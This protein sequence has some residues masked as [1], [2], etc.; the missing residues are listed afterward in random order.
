MLT[1]NQADLVDPNHAR[2][3][4]ELLND[5]AEDPMGGGR[6]LS[7]YA[8]QNLIS[9]L[10]Q[11]SDLLAILAFEGR[12]PAGLIIAF[13]GFS[14]F[15]CAPL[16][17]IHDVIVAKNFRRDGVSRTMFEFI[18]KIALDRNYCKLTLEVLEGNRAAQSAYRSFGFG[19]YELDPETGT[20]LFW[21]KILQ[22]L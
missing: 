12:E 20:A 2:A 6:P 5:Y 18:E 17:N 10:Q 14:T 3:L 16:L 19:D 15:L 9:K 22:Q 4:I 11:R 8:R 21:E 1:V 13:E 7:D